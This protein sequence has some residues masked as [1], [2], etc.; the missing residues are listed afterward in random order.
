M[1]P[2]AHCGLRIGSGGSPLWPRTALRELFV[3]TA[4]R[5]QRGRHL[6]LVGTR[7]IAAS[8]CF[9]GNQRASVVGHRSASE[10]ADHFRY[11]ASGKHQL[12]SGNGQPSSCRPDRAEGGRDGPTPDCSVLRCP[13]VVV[14]RCTNPI[15]L[16]RTNC[17]VSRGNANAIAVGL[18]S[19]GSLL[20]CA[21]TGVA[22]P[23]CVAGTII[24][25]AL[26]S[27]SPE[28]C[29]SDNSSS[30]SGGSSGSSSG[31]SSGGTDEMDASD[32]AGDGGCNPGVIASPGACMTLIN[33]YPPCAC[34]ISQSC[35]VVL[36]CSRR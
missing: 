5:W 23:V 2:C 7:G 26:V 6:L 4:D 27:D 3:N 36:R 11:V 17:N 35:V 19:V 18:T 31:S 25:I 28:A 29:A 21:A 34:Q 32:D 12:G 9:R 14:R 8:R 33:A 1:G 24:A 22:A 16:R 30:S 10:G 20:A 13:R 15:G